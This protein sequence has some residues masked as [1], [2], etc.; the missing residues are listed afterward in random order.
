MNLKWIGL[1]VMVWGTIWLASCRSTCPDPVEVSIDASKDT[2]LAIGACRNGTG[3]G[4]AALIVKGYQDDS[5]GFSIHT[6][7][8]LNQSLLQFYKTKEVHCKLSSNSVWLKQDWFD[9]Y[10]DTLFIVYRHKLV[11]KGQLNFTIYYSTS[12]NQKLVSS[13]HK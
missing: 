12:Q 10:Y 11:K 7:G 13:L 1:L 5:S 9:S 6:G 3:V 4:Q 2:I 8:P